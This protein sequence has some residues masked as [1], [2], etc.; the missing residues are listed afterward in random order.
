MRDRGNRAGRNRKSRGNRCE[1]GGSR[2]SR[3]IHR[4]GQVGNSMSRRILATGHLPR[5][6]SFSTLGKT[7]E[8]LGRAR[9][10]GRP[11]ACCQPGRDGK[12][13]KYCPGL[14]E[15]RTGWLGAREP[16]AHQRKGEV[17]PHSAPLGGCVCRGWMTSPPPSSNAAGVDPRIVRLDNPPWN[18]GD[19]RADSAKNRRPKSRG[20]RPAAHDSLR[21]RGGAR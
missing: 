11:R 14:N 16:Q 4:G 15:W 2:F 17:F 8:V 18:L 10:M 1:S 3:L 12:Q 9:I 19:C 13:C 6:E 7:P 5:T 20:S 21:S